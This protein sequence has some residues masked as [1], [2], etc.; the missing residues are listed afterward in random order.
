MFSKAVQPP[1]ISLFSST[2]T[3]CLSLFS[4]H[5]DSSLL[6]DSFVH[7]LDDESSL[8]I[9]T[10]PKTLIESF[11]L[12]EADGQESDVSHSRGFSISAPVLHIQSPTLRSGYIRCPPAHWNPHAAQRDR[13]LG[14]KLP[15][16]HMQVRNMGR[17]WCFEV[18]VVD[19]S[20]RFG[21]IRCSTFQVGL[22]DF[23]IL[24]GSRRGRRAACSC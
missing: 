6:A 8:P 9:P 1:I 24:T 23:H 14:I 18:G 17:A 12:D 15:W 5:T 7:V 10:P 13:E 16:V 19:S 22:P 20:G 21:C 2:S 3:Q 4:V 11:A